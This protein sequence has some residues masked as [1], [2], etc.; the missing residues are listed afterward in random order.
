MTILETRDLLA[1]VRLEIRTMKEL[2]CTTAE[3][4]TGG[5]TIQSISHGIRLLMEH[6]E[7]KLQDVE[8]ALSQRADNHKE[9]TT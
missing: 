9:A 5:D 7:G 8:E 1:D 6:I 3:D 2:I 4:V